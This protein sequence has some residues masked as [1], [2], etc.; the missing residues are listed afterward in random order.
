MFKIVKSSTWTKLQ[1]Q[2]K[3]EQR[4]NELQL[5]EVKKRDFLLNDYK[6]TLEQDVIEIAQAKEK[7]N[8]LQIQLHE[9]K[10]ALETCKTR[11]ADIQKDAD[12]YQ[13]TLRK[14]NEEIAERLQENKLLKARITELENIQCPECPDYT[15]IFTKTKTRIEAA[16]KELKNISRGRK[17]PTKTKVQ[18]ILSQ[19]VAELTEELK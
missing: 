5:K 2:L 8:D 1:S 16:L 13:A 4:N 11:R 6:K 10:L 12:Q 7:L 19:T 17:S 18:T 3:E 14:A 15:P 9:T